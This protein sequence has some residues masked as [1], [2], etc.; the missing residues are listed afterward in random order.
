MGHRRKGCNDAERVAERVASFG[1][2][3]RWGTMQVVG[4]LYRQTGPKR[5]AHTARNAV[6]VMP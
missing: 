1:D 5:G 3:D 6:V 4:D 2:D